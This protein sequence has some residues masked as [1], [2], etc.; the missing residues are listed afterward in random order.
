MNDESRGGR[1]VWT[2]KKVCFFYVP[3]QF[4]GNSESVQQGE[5]FIQLLETLFHPKAPV[6]KSTS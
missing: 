4:E 2:P 5:T 6:S 1:S 3:F